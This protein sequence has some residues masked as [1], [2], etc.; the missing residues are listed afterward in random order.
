M[1]GQVLMGNAKERCSQIQMSEASGRLHD[2]FGLSS[3]M[4]HEA[5]ILRSFT[6][7]T[8]VQV[9]RLLI[10]VVAFIPCA[11]VGL[12][13]LYAAIRSANKDSFG[14]LL[15]ATFSLWLAYLFVRAILRLLP[16]ITKSRSNTDGE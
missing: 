5:R 10:A 13:F 12:A 8:A 16:S 11:Y 4:A 6:L 3:F 7:W 14:W 1:P 15:I 9:I 2:L